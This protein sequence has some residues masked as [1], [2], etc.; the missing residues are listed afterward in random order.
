[1]SVAEQERYGLYHLILRVQTVAPLLSILT[2]A[3]RRK[4]SIE[5]SLQIRPC[6]EVERRVHVHEERGLR[7][8]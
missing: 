3:G 7:C 2:Y 1:M 4:N 5:M 8:H 6:R